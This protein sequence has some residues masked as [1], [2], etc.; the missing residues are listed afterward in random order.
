M[1]VW[2][3]I[4]VG[5]GLA[6]LV[7]GIT[8][9]ERG[10][11][12]MLVAE[13]VGSL[14]FASGVI[15]FG[16]F[17]ALREKRGHPF[18]LISEDQAVE[19][20]TKWQE[21]CPFYKGSWGSDEIVLTPLGETRQAGYVPQSLSAQ[22]LQAARRIILIAPQGLKDF[23]PRLFASNLSL[24]FPYAKV[25][26]SPL[27]AEKFAPQYRLGKSILATDYARYWASQEGTDFLRGF[28]METIRELAGVREGAVLVFPGL[29]AS[30]QPLMQELLATLTVSIVE[31]TMFP[32]SPVGMDLYR[33]LRKKFK[34]LG[35]EFLMS[36]KA[37][38]A[39]IEEGYCHSIS[40]QSQGKTLQLKAKSFVLAT[41]GLF[42][43]GIQVGPRTIREGVFDSPLFLPERWTGDGFL[44]PQPYAQTGIEVDS[45]LHPLKSDGQIYLR[46]VFVCGR[47]LAHWDP[48]ID[49]CGGG[50]A[51][52]TGYLAGS[53]L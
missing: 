19:S 39:V 24:N 4:I 26:I 36:G 51:L 25:T 42:G 20:I 35:G 40:L 38:A 50:V 47:T 34:D 29:S 43:G 33:F 12:V 13:G 16:D 49:Y 44:G 31:P 11:Q 53:K 9:A 17:Y 22:P 3:G 8:A 28:L 21:I 23:F 41:G 37:K 7:A 5:G 27:Q 48:W 2:D 30:F 1:M 52:T 45:D 6:G 32:P 46:N 14:S 15:D 10:K 18:S